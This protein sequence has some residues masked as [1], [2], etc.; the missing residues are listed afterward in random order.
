MLAVRFII[1]TITFSISPQKS[2]RRKEKKH[3][4]H[5][6]LS[7]SYKSGPNAFPPPDSLHEEKI[8]VESYN[9][10]LL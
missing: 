7:K 3:R 4:A 1:Y 5:Y 2:K 8:I 9:L 10:V 6:D